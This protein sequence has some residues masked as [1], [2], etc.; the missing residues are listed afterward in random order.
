MWFW[1]LGLGA[2]FGLGGVVG[3]VG[4]GVECFVGVF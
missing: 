4:L 3:F 1:G 2:L